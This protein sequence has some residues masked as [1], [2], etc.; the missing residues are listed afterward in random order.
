MKRVF[1]GLAMCLLAA[2][3]TSQPTSVT[4]PSAN[5]SVPSRTPAVGLAFAIGIPLGMPAALGACLQSP[6]NPDC[7]SAGLLSRRAGADVAAAAGPLNLTATVSGSTVTLAWSAPAGGDVSSYILEAGSAAGLANLANFA[8]NSTATSYVATRVPPGTYFVRVRAVTASGLSDP[9]NEV[10]VSVACQAPGAPGSLTITT[11][12]GGTVAFSW[13]AASGGP[14]SYA[15]QA[16]SA[17]GQSNLANSDLGTTAL[18][19]TATKVPAGTYYVRVLAKNACGLGAAS[20][21]VALVVSQTSTVPGPP[22]NFQMVISKLS[23]G[24]DFVVSWDPPASGAPTTYYVS[25]ISTGPDF[26][27]AKTEYEHSSG[28]LRTY[29]H[30]TCSFSKPGDCPP[31][32]Q[33]LGYWRMRAGTGPIPASSLNYVPDPVFVGTPS[34]VVHA[35]VPSWPLASTPLKGVLGGPRFWFFPR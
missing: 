23:G 3:C 18:S 22:R 26:V 6:S 10:T 9:S 34:N 16:G 30:D 14:T 12:S 28:D 8:T 20:N 17:S 24:L 33:D 25:E 1:G 19:Y 35:V 7:L 21:E 13:T 32:L 5:V 2:G 15:L 4:A 11:N 27:P 29:F 31:P